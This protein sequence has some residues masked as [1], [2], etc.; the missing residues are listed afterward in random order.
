[1]A[2]DNSV[3]TK[4]ELPALKPLVLKTKLAGTPTAK[5]LYAASVKN[6]AGQDVVLGCPKA[7]RGLVALMNVHAVVGGAA[8]HW[9]GPAAFAEINSAIHGLMF[10]TTG[11]PWHEA[12]NYVNDAG[13]AENGV[14]A[15]RANYGFDGM[16]FET[17]KGFRGVHSK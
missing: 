7:T 8:C 6:A 4:V 14:Y 12:F 16:T 2:A 17:L 11:R 10:A 3:V 9:G 5:P 15:L 1:M 13:H